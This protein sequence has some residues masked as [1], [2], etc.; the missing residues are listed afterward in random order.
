MRSGSSAADVIRCLAKG[1]GLFIVGCVVIC[2][3]PAFAD[4]A[5]ESSSLP[6]DKVF[7]RMLI[8]TQ[9]GDYEK[10]TKALSLVSPV[11]YAVDKV[12]AVRI[13]EEL[14]LAIASRDS[15]RVLA[16]VHRFIGLSICVLL[17]DSCPA[18]SDRN[19]STASIRHAYALYLV[20][21]HGVQEKNFQLSKDMKN[22]FRRLNAISGYQ[23]EEC[24]QLVRQIR[25]TLNNLFQVFSNVSPSL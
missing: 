16:T 8:L 1:T 18:G 24:H 19:A 12:F 22:T 4:P 20:L 2:L 13:E 17:L 14:N 6:P 25:Q 5:S 23:P 15:A 9:R 21:D 7:E 11:A 3:P 10:V